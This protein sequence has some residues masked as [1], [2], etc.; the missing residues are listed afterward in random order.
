MSESTDETVR[1]PNAKVSA[2]DEPSCVYRRDGVHQPDA[3]ALAGAGVGKRPPLAQL[4]NS[5]KAFHALLPALALGAF[6]IKRS[7]GPTCLMRQLLVEP[8]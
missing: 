7:P 2:F 4:G 5:C 3:V 8:A 6:F 1:S